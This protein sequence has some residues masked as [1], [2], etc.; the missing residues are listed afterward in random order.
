LLNPD[1]AIEAM[2]QTVSKINV[3]AKK[4]QIG[5]KNGWKA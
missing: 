2:L 4:K 3:H 1:S 5:T